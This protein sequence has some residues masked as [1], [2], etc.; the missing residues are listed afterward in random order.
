MSWKRDH[1]ICNFYTSTLK[2]I[3]RS[4]LIKHRYNKKK[5]EVNNKEKEQ[6]L[7]LVLRIVSPVYNGVYVI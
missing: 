3:G 4:Y 1:F 2:W 7:R 5:I 6:G